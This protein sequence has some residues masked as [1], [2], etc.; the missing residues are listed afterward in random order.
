M[1]MRN[2]GANHCSEFDLNALYSPIDFHCNNRS[3]FVSAG[4]ESHFPLKTVHFFGDTND[5]SDDPASCKHNGPDDG[6]HESILSFQ[7]V[8]PFTLSLPLDLPG[9]S[10]VLRKVQLLQD[11]VDEFL[12]SLD[13]KGKQELL[14]GAKVEISNVLR[15]EIAGFPDDMKL[16]IA[17]DEES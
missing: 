10:R 16:D 1:L 5:N 11:L 4:S 15:A 7:F 14:E 2:P 13:E 6:G 17:D 12:P 8:G 9:R 3:V